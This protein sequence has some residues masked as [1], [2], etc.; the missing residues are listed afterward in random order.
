MAITA[1]G[2]IAKEDDNTDFTSKEDWISFERLARQ[3]G[4][5]IIGHKTYGAYDKNQIWKEVLYLVMTRQPNQQSDQ[6]NVKFFSGTP[7]EALDYLGEL[8]FNQ[9]CIAGGGETNAYFIKEGLI[10]EVYLDVEP[11]VFSKGIPLF[12]PVVNFEFKLELLETKML[13]PKTIQLH[14]RVIK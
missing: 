5:L 1:N 8:K 4:N 3:T 13:S 7:K 6:E 14:Y 9:A 10:D 2:L 11:T 12:R